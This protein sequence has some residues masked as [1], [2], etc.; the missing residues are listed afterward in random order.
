MKTICCLLLVCFWSASCATT[1]TTRFA[2]GKQITKTTSVDAALPS[3]LNVVGGL[4][5]GLVGTFVKA[6]PAGD[7][8]PI[9]GLKK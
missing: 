1:T 2:D 6:S 5:G 7:L 8:P 3:I 4:V 9:N